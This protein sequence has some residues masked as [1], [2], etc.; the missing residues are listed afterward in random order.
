MTAPAEPGG[1]REA[2]ADAVAS[3]ILAHGKVGSRNGRRPAQT[4]EA[5]LSA[6]DERDEVAV[7]R[8]LAARRRDRAA[9]ARGRVPALSHDAVVHPLA[10]PVARAGSRNRAARHRARAAE[11]GALAARDRRAAAG[12]RE[13]AACERL[14]ALVDREELAGELALGDIDPLTGARA[15]AAGLATLEHELQRCRRTGVGFVVVYVDVVGLKALNDTQGHRAGDELLRRVVRHMYENLRAY[16]LVVRLGGDEFLC[17][18]SDMPLPEARRRFD[19][20]AAA[21]GA[22]P[23]GSAIRTGFAEYALG[24]SAAELI[25]RA[26]AQLISRSH[27][28]HEPPLTPPEPA[29][30]G[31][32]PH[33]RVPARAENVPALRR[34]VVAYAAAN[35]ASARQCDDVAVAVSEALGN[36]VVHAYAG[37]ADPGPATIDAWVSDG[38]LHVVVCD[39][40]GGMQP[41]RRGPGLGLGLSVIIRLARRVEVEESPAGTRLHMAFAIG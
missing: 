23:D 36:V 29:G 15:R 11:Q 1:S 2:A 10:A 9:D 24:E 5:R 22:A 35:G 12:D 25:A 31:A 8:D 14:H 18:A 20:I 40:G 13:Q 19:I 6:A 39:E 37:R 17:G 30:R 7:A 38:S 32:R 28:T 16:D 27:S 34:S 33:A 26:D 4:A 21:M 3:Q 41:R